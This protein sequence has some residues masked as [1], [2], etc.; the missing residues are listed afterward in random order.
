MK[1]HTQFLTLSHA[2]RVLGCSPA[3]VS[4]L[5]D[6]GVLPGMRDSG[7][8]RLVMAAG[9]EKLKRERE[10]THPKNHSLSTLRAR[11]NEPH[12]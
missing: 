8:R 11:A 3:W 4:A 5:F 1:E 2:A 9:V 12:R 7:G 6:R 10:Q